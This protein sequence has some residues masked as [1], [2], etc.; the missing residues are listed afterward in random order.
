MIP[1]SK[2]LSLGE[3]SKGELVAYSDY[4]YPWRIMALKRGVGRGSRRRGVGG[5]AWIG[6]TYGTKYTSSGRVAHVFRVP[7]TQLS[8][9]E[10][11]LGP[12]KTSELTTPPPFGSSGRS[13]K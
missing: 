13:K 6:E 2:I 1:D 9:T 3:F 11:N 7:L 10:Q 12:I 4:D 8:K 5:V